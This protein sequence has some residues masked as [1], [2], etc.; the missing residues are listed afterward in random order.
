MFFYFHLL[1]YI[2]I[3]LDSDCFVFPRVDPVPPVEN[4]DENSSVTVVHGYT[5]IVMA[6][7][8]FVIIYKERI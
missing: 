7:A 8:A 1:K 6:L 5:T 3:I 2:N 4:C